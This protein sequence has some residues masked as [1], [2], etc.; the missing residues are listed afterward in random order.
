VTEI[1]RFSLHQKQ[2]K[3]KLTCCT[4]LCVHL[5]VHIYV[6]EALCTAEGGDCADEEQPLWQESVRNPFIEKS[7]WG[8][9][10]KT[11][12]LTAHCEKR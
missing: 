8:R 2:K 6:D 1:P 7:V 5:S 9:E 12:S 11:G 10:S 3:I 4:C